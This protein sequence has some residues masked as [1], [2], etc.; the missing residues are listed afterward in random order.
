MRFSPY[1]SLVSLLSNILEAYTTAFFVVDP[2]KRLLNLVAVETLSRYLSPGL[3]LPLDQSGIISQVQKANQRIRIDKLQES[4]QSISTTLPFY[5]EGEGHIKGL[6]AVPVGD[7]AGVLYVDTKYG[8]G[9]NDKQQKWIL[10]FAAVLQELLVQQ[11]R[12]AQQIEYSRIAE[13]WQR[14]DQA[15]FKGAAFED[16]CQMVINECSQLL[17]TEYGFLALQERGEDRYHLFA[18]TSNVPRNFI[19]QHFLLKQGLIGHIFQTRKPLLISRLNPHAPE[20]FL[21]SS[22]E[23]LPHHGTLW[24]LPAPMSLGQTVVLAFLSRETIEWSADC[25][26]AITHML[27]FFQLL[28]EQY[29]FKEECRQ[30]Q[31]YDLSTGVLNVLAFETRLDSAVTSSMQKS[32]PFTLALFQ[33]EPWQNLFTTFPPKQV[34][35]WQMELAV[36]LCGELAPN[37][38]V[39]QIAENRFAFLFPEMTVQEAKRPISRLMDFGQQ[40]FSGKLR[41]TRIRPHIA[42]V[43][44]PQDGSNSEQ[45][46]SL[47]YQRLLASLNPGIENISS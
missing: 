47:I 31:T 29:Y 7:G 40:F 41:G 1:Q 3:S 44:F 33:F 8:W 26:K 46:W 45:L 12:V 30:L 42:W 32:N 20:H 37:I 17:G 2:Q 23:G 4:T 39:G 35:Q 25:R 28:L 18:V 21:F 13:F 9:F 10:E 14:M 34:R 16:Y 11:E 36:G 43:G 22:G 19:H 6:L 15:A 27:H 5:R 38:L 24:G